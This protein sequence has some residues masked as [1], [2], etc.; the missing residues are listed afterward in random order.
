M[1][2]PSHPT[3]PRPVQ[4]PADLV[5]AAYQLQDLLLRASRPSAS[6]EAAA[7]I[8]EGLA[9]RITARINDP[10]DRRAVIERHLDFGAAVSALTSTMAEIERL[11]RVFHDI[12]E[13]S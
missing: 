6:L 4:A 12:G 2:H 11:Q 1:S 13:A 5:A 3:A 8:A 10:A 9:R 7:R